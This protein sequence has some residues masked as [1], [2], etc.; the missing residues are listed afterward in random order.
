M[1]KVSVPTGSSGDWKVEKFTVSPE[2][3]MWH[4][5][6]AGGRGILPGDYTM[7]RCRSTVVMSD[8]QAEMM[9]HYEPVR[10]AKGNILINGLGLGLVLLNCMLKEGVDH[11][12]VVERSKDVIS[13]VAP[14]YMSTYADR[15]TIIHADTFT[16]KPAKGTRYGMVWHDIW[17]DICADNYDGM[18]KLHRRYGRYSDWQGSWCRTQ[19]KRLY[20]N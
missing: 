16:Y 17:P 4:N 1:K 15:L 3:A 9:D 5:I 7:L 20:F 2:Q 12:T 6:R 13:L 18:K 10:R 19:V 11:I 8:T 14:H